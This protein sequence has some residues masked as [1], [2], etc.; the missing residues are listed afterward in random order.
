SAGEAL[1]HQVRWLGQHGAGLPLVHLFE[2]GTQSLWRALSAMDVSWLAQCPAGTRIQVDECAT[3]VG[4]VAKTLTYQP[5]DEASL[6]PGLSRIAGMPAVDLL[7]WMATDT[8]EL[9]ARQHDTLRLQ[10][11]SLRIVKRSDGS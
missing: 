8:V 3:T 9:A 1:L 2:G 4:A 5:L 6:L 7:V 11:V 10:L